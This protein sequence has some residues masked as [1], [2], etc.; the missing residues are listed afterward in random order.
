MH[1]LPSS[2]KVCATCA[3]WAGQRTV[4]SIYTLSQ[5]E[6]NAKGMC[7]GGGFNRAQ[8]GAMSTCNKWQKWPVLK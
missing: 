3:F 4:N 5:F 8:T 2:F 6:L 7:C 1:S